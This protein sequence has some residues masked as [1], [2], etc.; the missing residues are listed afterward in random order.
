LQLHPDKCHQQ[1]SDGDRAK[2]KRQFCRLQHA[3]E[4]LTDPEKRKDYDR[5]R[6]SGL[7]I[8]Y[9][10]W[11]SLSATGLHNSIH[12]MTPANR[13]RALTGGNQTSSDVNRQPVHTQTTDNTLNRFRQFS[14]AGTDSAI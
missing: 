11:C 5:W 10:K 8:S 2:L 12:W 3:K 4:V 6:Q 13:Q 14:E 9:R 1:Q 7:S